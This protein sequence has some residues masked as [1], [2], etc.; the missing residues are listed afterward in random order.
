MITVS[1]G[2]YAHWQWNNGA[3]GQFGFRSADDALAA[4]WYR[5]GRHT[6]ALIYT[7]RAK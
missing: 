7:R 1:F 4:A 3:A 2:E 5:C 6:P